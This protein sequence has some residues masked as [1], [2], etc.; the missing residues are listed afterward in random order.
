MRFELISKRKKLKLTQAALAKKVGISRAAY[1]K[2]EI[3]LRT[4]S[5][6]TAM[7]IAEALGAKVERIFFTNVV[8]VGN[9]GE[10]KENG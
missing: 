2:Y 8:P 10:G 3:G 9:N 1:A 6:T 4:P 5:V 7:S